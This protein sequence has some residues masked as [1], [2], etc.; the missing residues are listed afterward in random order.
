MDFTPISHADIS[1]FLMRYKELSALMVLL[2]SIVTTLIV[3]PKIILI[4]KK[5]NLTATT[6]ARTS[7]RGIV[8]TLG[9]IGVFTG[10]LLSANISAVLFASYGQLIDL[11]IFNILVLMLLLV[12][13]LD[14]IMTITA[15]KKFLYQLI[16]AFAFIISTNIFIS[17]FSGLFGMT[18]IPTGIGMIFSVFVIVL[19]INAYNLIDGI[20]GLAGML[21][22]VISGFLAIVFYLSDYYFLSLISLSLV[23][24]LMAFL[25]FNFSR[26]LKIF[27]GDTGSMVVGFVLA[28]QVVLYLHLSDLKPELEVFKNAPIFVL[29]LLSYPLLDT[30]RVFFIRIKNGRSPFSADRN[31]IH[32]RLIDLGLAHKYATVII[33]IYTMFIT[34]LTFLLNDFPINLVFA[35]I[36]PVAAGIML[37]PFV[38][39]RKRNK[40]D[41]VFPK[42]N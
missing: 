18:H 38:V 29:A 7:H 25:V 1:A 40:Y 31:H 33:A 15:R 13:V 12:G 26:R 6:N 20:D 30:L 23:G 22:T 10:L 34:V 11:M 42:K 17:S 37:L 32:H 16:I 9:G 3:M 39:H 19:I 8:P 5:K 36:L 14:D 21:G 27:L 24:S 4:S 28:V 35:I 2:F 41:L